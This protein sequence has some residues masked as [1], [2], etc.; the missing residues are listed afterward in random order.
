MYKEPNIW[1]LM[2]QYMQLNE[3]DKKRFKQCLECKEN[4]ETCG[5]TEKDEING[6]CAKF[7]SRWANKKT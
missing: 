5:C 4:P 6:L 3:E 2:Q 7:N 1:K